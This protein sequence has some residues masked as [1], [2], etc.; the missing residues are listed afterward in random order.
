VF[1]Y[2]QLQSRTEPFESGSRALEVDER[3]ALG[4][5]LCVDSTECA[6]RPCCAKRELGL[7]AGGER[8][9]R[10]VPRTF[11]IPGG[12]PTVGQKGVKRSLLFA[13]SESTQSVDGRAEVFDRGRQSERAQ[14]SKSQETARESV[15]RRIA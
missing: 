2:P 10:F 6:F 3:L 8:F 11:A 1:R 5:A 13:K 12:E 14:T 15:P 7:V 4:A 9:G